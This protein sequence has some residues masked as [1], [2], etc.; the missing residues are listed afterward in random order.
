[1]TINDVQKILN[2]TVVTQSTYENNSVQSGFVGDLLSVVMGK[3]K[4]QCAW[5]T[6][7]GHINIIAVGTLINVACIIVTEDFKVDEDAISKANEEGI[8][9]M[10]THLSSY[11]SAALLSKNGLE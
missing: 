9:I 10:T 7:Q 4:E 5:I 1:M 3:A 8:V 2:A 6:I 11:E